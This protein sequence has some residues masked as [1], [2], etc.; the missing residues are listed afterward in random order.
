M[1]EDGYP[2]VH[3]LWLAD[4][5]QVTS[6]PDSSLLANESC[7][8]GHD[9]ACS[10]YSYLSLLPFGVAAQTNCHLQ[11]VAQLFHKVR[12]QEVLGSGFCFML[13][14]RL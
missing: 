14:C 6:V 2:D 4:D 9:W 5:M 7:K 10:G 13:C 12:K 1:P 3:G 11:V 8:L